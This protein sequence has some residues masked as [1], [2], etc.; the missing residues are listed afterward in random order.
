MVSTHPGDHNYKKIKIGQTSQFS[1]IACFIVI[2]YDEFECPM[3][4]IQYPS[5][6]TV[7]LKQDIQLHE[8]IV[9]CK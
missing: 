5:N 7:L 4:N 1:G 8:L 3:S 6:F 9:T 2:T